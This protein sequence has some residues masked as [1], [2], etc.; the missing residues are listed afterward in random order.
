MFCGNGMAIVIKPKNIYNKD[1]KYLNDNAIRSAST[2]VHNLNKE[3][4]VLSNANITFWREKQSDVDDKYFW[5]GSPNVY[6]QGFQF[7]EANHSDTSGIY[8]YD[9]TNLTIVYKYEEYALGEDDYDYDIFVDYSVTTGGS[10]VAK[11]GAS[12]DMCDSSFSGNKNVKTSKRT[13]ESQEANLESIELKYTQSTIW[14]YD[15]DD[16]DLVDYIYNNIGGK[17]FVIVVLLNHTTSS[18]ISYV[19]AFRV[20]DRLNGTYNYLVDAQYSFSVQLL[21]DAYEQTETQDNT[22]NMDSNELLADGIGITID[23]TVDFSVFRVMNGLLATDYIKIKTSNDE[24]VT[25]NVDILIHEHENIG[26][27]L[28]PIYGD[29]VIKVINATIQNGNSESAQCLTSTASGQVRLSGLVTYGTEWDNTIQFEIVSI[30]PKYDDTY[31]Y[32]KY[33]KPIYSIL[34]DSVI[35]NYEDGKQTAVL[36]CSIDDYYDEQ[37]YWDANRSEY[38]EYVVDYSKIEI[39]KSGADNLP[40]L[41]KNNDIVRPKI[42][43]MVETIVNGKKKMEQQE[44][45]LIDGKKFRVIGV[46]VKYD[47]CIMQ[48]L[49]LQEEKTQ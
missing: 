48:E 8:S 14:Y 21:R 12:Y 34:Q 39:S 38:Q 17:T 27:A 24:L 9:N 28:L 23:N 20:F 2:A 35:D 43:R 41:F 4:V 49:T 13:D 31:V 33:K 42:V 47:G 45:D 15:G 7:Y 18:K 22:Y 29:N 5:L 25:S 3:L 11:T 16:A 37:A 30:T 26:T 6:E 19:V 44:T 36:E 1:V 40:I 10:K 46:R 32:I